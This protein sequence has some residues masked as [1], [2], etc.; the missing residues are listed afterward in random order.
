MATPTAS[1]QLTLRQQVVP[2]FST[3]RAVTGAGTEIWTQ[4][5]KTIKCKTCQIRP[6]FITHEFS[7]VL[8]ETV[9]LFISSPL[10][11]VTV[12]WYICPGCRDPNITW[13]W[14]LGTCRM[15]SCRLP[16]YRETQNSS[17]SPSPGVQVTLRLSSPRLRW[18]FLTL[19]GTVKHR[20]HMWLWA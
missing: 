14:S 17:T 6:R 3:K 10:T 19:L 11:E 4:V 13:F 18:M 7:P 15:S 12:T 1:C 9:L 5:N 8:P 2:R 16:R 20:K